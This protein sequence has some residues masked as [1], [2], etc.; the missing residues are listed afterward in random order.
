MNKYQ[1]FAIKKIKIEGDA[2]L[3]SFVWDCSKIILEQNE[4]YNLTKYTISILQA[5]ITKIEYL[6]NNSV[7]NATRVNEF[8][9]NIEL[10]FN[11]KINSIRLYFIENI[12]EPVDIYIEYIE[13]DRS[14]YDK[15][16]QEEHQKELTEKAK[17]VVKTGDSLI[18]VIFQPVN[19]SF[20]YS[21]VELYAITGTKVV[22][23]NKENEYQLMA[24]YK[25]PEDVYF[26]SITGL[27]YGQ[28]AIILVEYDSSNKEIFKSD[29][30]IVNLIAGNYGKNVVSF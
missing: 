22:S 15:K 18:N 4:N 25:T 17:V 3:K 10:D 26:H 6:M 21:K 8:K 1:D 14:I 13:A 19:D 12:V 7:Y 11:N 30:V 2:T 24:K 9:H 5:S 23:N 16:M 20:A 29:Y 27:A 28:Y